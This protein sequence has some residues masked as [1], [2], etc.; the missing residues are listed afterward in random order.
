MHV[1]M[2]GGIAYDMKNYLVCNK[3][4]KVQRIC[5][6]L[7]SDMQEKNASESC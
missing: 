3:V 4:K 2:F 1:D 6:R 7:A 5:E